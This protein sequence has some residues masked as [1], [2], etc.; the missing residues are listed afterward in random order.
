MFEDLTS[1]SQAFQRAPHAA[2]PIAFE[3]AMVGGA[4]ATGWLQGHMS[5]GGPVSV[6]NGLLTS[7]Y[8]LHFATPL[9]MGLWLWARRR[10]DL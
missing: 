7:E 4:V 1:V 5:T 3:R 10:D 8:L 9:T 6:L 2:G